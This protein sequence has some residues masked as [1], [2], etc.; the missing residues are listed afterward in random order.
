MTKKGETECLG[1][2]VLGKLKGWKTQTESGTKAWGQL[3]VVPKR[4]LHP[5]PGAC[6]WCPGRNKAFAESLYGA[7]TLGYSDGLMQPQT[8]L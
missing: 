6:G 7:L 4:R 5:V 3:E 8:F 2:T 1:D